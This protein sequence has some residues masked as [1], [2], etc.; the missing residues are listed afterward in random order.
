MKNVMKNVMVSRASNWIL[1]VLMTGAFATVFAA[2]LI[3][4]IVTPNSA[5][6]V[7]DA[8]C[9]LGSLIFTENAKIS[10]TLAVTTNNSLFTN[11]FGITSGTSNCSATQLTKNDIEAE[12]YAEA[13]FQSLR[14]DMARGQG[15]SLTAFGQLLG[16]KDASLP[17][18]GK[19]TRAHY[20]EIYPESDVTPVQMILSVRAQMSKESTLAQGCTRS[21]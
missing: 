12:K 15:E 17:E 5:W 4:V 21:I 16:C 9:G 13:N 7:G 8:G 18:L 2:T 20:S 3:T 11:L 6:A 19:L 14:V 10:Q 1:T